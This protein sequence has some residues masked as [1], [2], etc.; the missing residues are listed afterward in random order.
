MIAS[1]D[2]TAYLIPLIHTLDSISHQAKLKSTREIISLPPAFDMLAELAYVYHNRPGERSQ[3]QAK[4]FASQAL[5][6]STK[7]QSPASEVA[8]F[9]ESILDSHW[10]IV[11]NLLV[12]TGANLK[13][14][15]ESMYR[16]ENSE[17]LAELIEVSAP[18][19]RELIAEVILNLTSALRNHPEVFGTHETPW[20]RRLLLPGGETL[21]SK[22]QSNHHEPGSQSSATVT[23][24]G[25]LQHSKND[26]VKWS[27]R[28]FEPMSEVSTLWTT[29]GSTKL[30]KHEKHNP[31]LGEARD[32]PRS[33]LYD[34]LDPTEPRL[35]PPA[36]ADRPK[37]RMKRLCRVPPWACA[38]LSS[39]FI[40]L[41]AVIGVL[42]GLL[43]AEVQQNKSL[44]EQLSRVND[45]VPSCQTT[46]IV[47]ACSATG[48]ATTTAATS[49][50]TDT[51]SS[52]GLSTGAKA[53]IG[54]AV[55][56]G[57]LSIIPFLYWCAGGGRKKVRN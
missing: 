33:A 24:S 8:P 10:T 26:V 13:G 9:I 41:I 43:G 21:E 40:A 4:L 29:L 7:I 22:E 57:I 47:S 56:F 37:S 53:G 30:E 27:N 54:I 19:G 32:P 18:I 44:R 23:M 6:S 39:V 48:T 28:L 15:L 5:M 1:T 16:N 20:G 34:T 36:T 38:S 45:T 35:P 12:L 17:I 31:V 52:S 51:T 14:N 11:Q 25:A 49:T 50:A 55:T 3:D 2:T 46:A 42:G